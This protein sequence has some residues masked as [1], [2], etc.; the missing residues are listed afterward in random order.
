MEILFCNVLCYSGMDERKLTY[1]ELILFRY[2]FL[3]SIL[4]TVTIKILL[5]KNNTFK[6]MLR[7]FCSIY[8][9][10]R[11]FLLFWFAVCLK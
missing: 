6:Y 3:D 11:I 9:K 8:I 10:Q 1:H 2:N 7:V 5:V 4:L